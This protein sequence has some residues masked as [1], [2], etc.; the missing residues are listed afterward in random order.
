MEI[1]KK[2]ILSISFFLIFSFIFPVNADIESP[3][4]Q[5]KQGIPAEE[6]RCKEG[7]ELVI[8]TNTMPACVRPETMDKMLEKGII[9]AKKI[10]KTDSEIETVP[11]SSMSVVNFYITD[12]DLNLSCRGIEIVSTKGLFEFTINGISIQG[13]EKMIETDTIQ[14]NFI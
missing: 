9:L 12:H 13:P 4:K 1:N 7:L 2:I 8:R 14:V 10:I 11:A 3:R 6:I 5:M